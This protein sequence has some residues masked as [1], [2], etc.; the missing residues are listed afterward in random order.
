MDRIYYRQTCQR[1][2]ASYPFEP[3]KITH[4]CGGSYEKRIYNKSEIEQDG[5]GPMETA[6]TETPGSDRPSRTRVCYIRKPVPKHQMK[7]RPPT[8]KQAEYLKLLCEQL[9]YD[10]EQYDMSQLRMEE[11]S[12]VIS[13]LKEELS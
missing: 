12:R 7:R 8:V 6:G 13:E 9:G 4:Y 2:G 3:G 10:Y 1:C 5:H 11:V